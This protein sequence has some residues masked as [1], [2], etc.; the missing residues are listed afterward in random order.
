VVDEA[1]DISVGQLRFLALSGRAAR[2][3][4]S[5]RVIWG[6]GSFN[7][8]FPWKSARRRCPGAGPAHC[9]SI[10][11]PRT[12]FRMQA[13][14]LLGPEV[15]DV[16]GNTEERR[17]TISHSTAHRRTSWFWTLPRKRSRLSANG[18]RNEPREGVV[19][20]EI[21]VFVRS[22]AEL[23][24]ARAAV[25][26]AKLPYKVLDD[27]VETPL[28]VLRFSTMHLAKGLEFRT[29]VVMACDDEVI[30]LQERIETVAD[31]ADLKRSTTRNGTLLYVACTRARDHLFGVRASIRRRSSG[32]TCG[33]EGPERSERV[34]RFEL[35]KSRKQFESVQLR[36]KLRNSEPALPKSIY[37]LWGNP[38]GQMPYAF[39]S[40]QVPKGKVASCSETALILKRSVMWV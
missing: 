15:S 25:E 23:E 14:R 40:L 18:W 13:D 8:R 37:V 39:R 11:G 28:A 20:H 10:T 21:G 1:Q 32:M 29:V 3:A 30:P 12:R 33:S 16:D 5:L 17:G 2:I 6:N 19:P 36:Q 22:P 24:R 27:N 4:S 7:S 9:E 35:L 31:D 26:D 38:E 34:P